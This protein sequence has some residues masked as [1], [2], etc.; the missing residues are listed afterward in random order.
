[1]KAYY[2]IVNEETKLVEYG[3]GTNTTFYESIGMVYGDIEQ[4][5]IDG[6]YYLAG[7][8][9]MKTEEDKAQEEAERV[10]KLKMTPRDFLLAL[11][12]LGVDYQEIKQLKATNPQV[13]IE[14]D[15]CNHIY[16]GN[17]L[18][19][20]LAPQFNITKEQLDTLFKEK[21]A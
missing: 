13:E 19:D 18:L 17:P 11:V 16:R 5:D 6:C 2:K 21:G 4:S 10:A 20:Q 9:P 7:Y 15:Y 3:T 14:L 12:E 8:A 1:M